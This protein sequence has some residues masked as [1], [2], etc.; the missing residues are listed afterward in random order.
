M[1]V[2]SHREEEEEEEKKTIV[3]W[4][5]EQNIETQ[6]NGEKLEEILTIW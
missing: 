5:D 1:W 3:A 2:E 6:L 4:D